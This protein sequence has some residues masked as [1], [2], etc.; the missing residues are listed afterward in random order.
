MRSAVLFTVVLTALA[1]AA[2]ATAGCFATAG[3]TAPPSTVGPGDTWT[4]RVT[5][6]QHGVRPIPDAQPTV[7]IVG[8]DG[9]RKTFAAKPTDK[10]GVY[11][12]S[13]VFPTSGQWSLEAND[14]FV[15]REQGQT[16][17]CSTTHTF[18]SVTIGGAGSSG[19]TSGDPAAAPAVQ[20]A[21]LVRRRRRWGSRD[22]AHRRSSGR[23]RGRDRHRRWPAARLAATFRPRS[24]ARP[25]RT[26][27]PT[28]GARGRRGPR[29]GG[30]RGR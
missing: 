20:P 12:A 18:G 26:A 2:E 6:K 28:P 3:L 17:D 29:R 25:C 1:L 4:A 30:R 7:T 10:V 8:E 9:A 23:P 22:R 21:T 11:A 15:A 19:P 16:W 24:R 13:V 27:R 14:G 5:V